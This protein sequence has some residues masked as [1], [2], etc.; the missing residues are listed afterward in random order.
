V[1]QELL[2]TSYE[3]QGL[4][5]GGGGFCTVLSTEGMA[6]NTASALEK[7]SGYKHPFDLH[8]ERSQHNPVNYRH[9]VLMLGGTSHNVL[10]RV[11][12]LRHEHTGR[13]NKL[14][15]H[16]VLGIRELPLGGPAHT[17]RHPGFSRTDWDRKVRLVASPSLSS[18]P[19]T[20]A[21]PVR[22]DAWARI[23]GDAG[24]AGAVAE[25]LS[26]GPDA[27]A[28]VIFPLKTDCLA[29]ADEVL[30][31][32]PPYKRWGVTFST[33]Y[34]SA[35]P[36][37]SCNLRFVLDGTPEAEKIRR[38]HRLWK[39][40]LASSLSRAPDTPLATAARTG[41]L[42]HAEAPARP[43][44]PARGPRPGK[45][46][47]AFDDDD[48]GFNQA[49]PFEGN[50]EDYN[51]APLIAASE[52]AAR[53]NGS[54]AVAALPPASRPPARTGGSRW[55]F[56]AVLGGLALCLALLML[57]G[58]GIGVAMIATSGDEASISTAAESAS[59]TLST[60]HEA[61]EDD[62][63][64][65]PD[66][67]IAPSA[68]PTE[69]QAEMPTPGEEAVAPGSHSAD[70]QPVKTRGGTSTDLSTQNA[71]GEANGNL[72]LPPMLAEEGKGTLASSDDLEIVSAPTADL[73]PTQSLPAE[74]TTLQWAEELSPLTK[75]TGMEK[76]PATTTAGTVTGLPA[77]ELTA[78]R[79]IGPYALA[80]GETADVS[81][82]GFSVSD[83]E[84]RVWRTV[85]DQIRPD[86]RQDAVVANIA[87]EAGELKVA[88]S[89]EVVGA[90]SE[91]RHMDDQRPLLNSLRLHIL[92]F[93]VGDRRYFLPLVKPEAIN[94]VAIAP[95]HQRTIKLP[96][97]PVPLPLSVKPA[98]TVEVL[99][100]QALPS[101]FKVK[102]SESGAKISI[103]HEDKEA[104]KRFVLVAT[105]FQLERT[106]PYVI[107]V[108]C[109]ADMSYL[110]SRT[111]DP[112]PVKQSLDGA[113]QTFERLQFPTQQ[114][115]DEI[116]NL[117]ESL[118]SAKD[119]DKKSI[120]GRIQLQT[121]ALTYIET[122]GRVVSKQ[123]ELIEKLKVSPLM[124]KVILTA[125]YPDSG[126]KIPPVVL[127][128]SK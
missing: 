88:W 116:K 81:R 100:A 114:I 54:G 8:D 53:R 70:E 30:R 52:A 13:S 3:G 24:W 4:R 76:G 112:G 115:R 106:D 33:Y 75:P 117:R 110:D 68:D 56:I 39:V 45:S 104:G 72:E 35:I 37:S 43:K 46:A 63:A 27:A 11:A 122:A 91:F 74:P 12:D 109:Q 125:M 51:L 6:A 1:I 118:K 64:D 34:T 22:C 2:F 92:A 126:E 66:D 78:I 119:Q 73:P 97:M 65:D 5:K 127:F 103:E 19:A 25:E 38:D 44:T 15:H 123:R 36:G 79:L 49:Y 107:T 17:L 32:I 41:E 105:E 86:K 71:A 62:Q 29:L 102:T 111:G 101:E 99:N 48:F 113:L 47:A 14:A 67:P 7:L 31:L 80:E 58:G 59:D 90:N 55:P 20:E 98:L 10:S 23:A 84:V 128:E 69:K 82:N 95:A 50:V 9:A 83:S 121:Q 40:D 85:K 120:E 21:R 16:V 124:A 57:I 108:D 26:A 77:G 18:L 89:D 60:Q 42:T 28:H 61:K 87:S 93:S 96:E 94:L